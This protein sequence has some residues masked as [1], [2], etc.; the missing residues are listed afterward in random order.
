[1]DDLSQ[2]AASPW[3]T[4]PALR[5][6][7]L[8]GEIG[9]TAVPASQALPVVFVYSHF[10]R[11][12][13]K[14][15][16]I[17]YSYSVATP[18][19]TPTVENY[20]KAIDALCREAAAGEAGSPGSGGGGGGAGDR[21]AG[22]DKGGAAGVARIAAV[23]GVTKGTV[24]A[25]VRRLARTGLVLAEPYGGVRLTAKGRKVA[26]DVL[27]RHRLIE[28]FL[29][30]VVGLDWSEVHAEAERLEHAV[31][32]RLIDRLDEMLGRPKYDPHGDPIPD[33]SGQTPAPAGLV[34]L[35]DCATG[36]RV[37]IGRISDQAS[38]FLCFVDRTGLR[39]GATVLVERVDPMA[40]AIVLKP[41]GRPSVTVS[42]AV[43]GKVLAR[44]RS[45]GRSGA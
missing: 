1:M 40:G 28:L 44:T 12:L 15:R 30:Q 6:R 16:N 18:A 33:A 19:P 11:L 32:P 5:S 21:G 20:I 24:S 22:G 27:R 17:C 3:G 39:P 25:M 23:L 41:Q 8:L 9:H 14:L 2:A 26:S 4:P 43:A 7:L 42:L 36:E 29:V 37:V 35:C 10:C 34:P 45:A 31:S 13:D 38:E